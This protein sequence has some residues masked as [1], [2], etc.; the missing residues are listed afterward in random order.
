MDTI[1]GRDTNLICVVTEGDNVQTE[2]LAFLER[3]FE[4]IVQALANILRIDVVVKTN[5][6]VASSGEVDTEV[7]FTEDMR[8]TPE[9]M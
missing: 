5:D 4:Y 2:G 8:I 7:Q 3:G 1:V 9:M 6:I